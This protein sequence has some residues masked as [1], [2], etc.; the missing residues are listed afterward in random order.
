MAAP[1][2]A[3]RPYAVQDVAHVLEEALHAAGAPNPISSASRLMRTSVIRQLA[4]EL[5]ELRQLRENVRTFRACGIEFGLGLRCDMPKGHPPIA[6]PDWMHSCAAV[7]P[8]AA[9]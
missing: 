6:P 1:P 5:E 7:A 3:R 4:D 9:T 8:L 2:A